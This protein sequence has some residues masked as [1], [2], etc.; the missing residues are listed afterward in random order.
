M[1]RIDWP[2]YNRALEARGEIQMWFDEEIANDWYADPLDHIGKP[3]AA[4][5]YSDEA[6]MALSLIRFR[7]GLSLRATRGFA[8]SLADLMEMKIEIPCY[9]TLSRRLAKLQ[10]D[11]EAAQQEGSV[12][13]VVDSTGLKVYGEGEWKVRIHGKSKR[14][15]WRKLHLAVNEANDTIL[16]VVFSENSFKDSE[17]FVDLMDGVDANIEQA[18]GDGAYDTDDCY[19]WSE[20]SGVNGVFPPRR[21][22]VIAQHGNQSARP[23][24][25]DQHI[26]GIRDVGRKQWKKNSDYH[27]RSIAETSMYRFKVL[28]GDKLASRNFENQAREAFV[29]CK[30]INRMPTPRG[31][32]ATA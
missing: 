29:R 25:R 32:Q 14:R 7:F 20:E 13:V 18:T 21:G 8:K 30:I 2:L 22:A 10:V 6:I 12:H 31:L 5:V 4:F 1:G 9:S 19:S 26:R 16:S 15:T 23:L 11:L 28:T 27:R 24:Q 3:G 17:V